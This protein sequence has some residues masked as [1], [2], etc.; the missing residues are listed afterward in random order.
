MF[1]Q[2]VIGDQ[3][4]EFVIFVSEILI[5]HR[6][7]LDDLVLCCHKSAATRYNQCREIR[8]RDRLPPAEV[9]DVFR[10]QL[11]L[12]LRVSVR[13]TRVGLQLADWNEFVEAAPHFDAIGKGSFFECVI[14]NEARYIVNFT[15]D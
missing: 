15:I 14:R 3:Q 9:A 11:D 8:E 5:V 2:V 12:A 10:D 1:R 13:V 7:N 6:H 4:G